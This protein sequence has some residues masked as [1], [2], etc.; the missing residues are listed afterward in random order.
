VILLRIM[1]GHSIYIPM[2]S[3]SHAKQQT[4]YVEKVT[5]PP[6]YACPNC[7]ARCV[8][9]R[10]GQR[11]CQGLTENDETRPRHYL[12]FMETCIYGK[13]ILL[14]MQPSINMQLAVPPAMA[15]CGETM[16]A[17]W[18]LH[19]F[20]G[21]IMAFKPSLSASLYSVMS[22]ISGQGSLMNIK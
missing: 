4:R 20:E 12:R 16:H 3:N 10:S 1:S 18:P 15:V 22:A 2:P 9:W 7:E 14:A 17:P 11:R 21:T 5:F 8:S 6:G 13:I 19:R